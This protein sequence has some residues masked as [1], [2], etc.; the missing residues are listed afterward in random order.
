MG[1]PSAAD[2]SGMTPERSMTTRPRDRRARP[3]ERAKY[4]SRTFTM[5][6]KLAHSLIHCSSDGS[7]EGA[8]SSPLVDS[9]SDRSRDPMKD[10]QIMSGTAWPPSQA[11]LAKLYE[12]TAWSSDRQRLAGCY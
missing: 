12:A 10:G 11:R 5:P 6:S 8:G 4:V 1:V 3:S 9:V 2:V 7:D